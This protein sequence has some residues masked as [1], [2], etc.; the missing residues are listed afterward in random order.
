MSGLEHRVS[1]GRVLAGS[2]STLVS[3]LFIIYYMSPAS[4]SQ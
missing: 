2:P 1:F 4:A 3:P